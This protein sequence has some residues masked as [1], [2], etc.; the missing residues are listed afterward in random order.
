MFNFEHTKLTQTQS[1]ALA[2][3]LTQFK[4][5]YETSKFDVG[6]IKVELNLPLKATEIFRKQR[7]TRIPLLLQDRV[8]HLANSLTHFDIIAPVNTDFLTEGNGFINTVIILKKEKSV[9]IVLDAG[10]LN[11]MID[12]TNCSWPIEPFEI[13]LTRIKGPIFSLAE[14]NSR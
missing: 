7:A 6:K 9:K 8:P 10:Q 1:E 5:R 13:I 11:T 12:E 3:L 4:Q 2:Q 14:M